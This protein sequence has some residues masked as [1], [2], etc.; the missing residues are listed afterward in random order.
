MSDVD[1]TRSAGPSALWAGPRDAPAVFVLDPDG[2]GRHGD[3]PAAWRPLVEHLQVLWCRLPAADG[4]WREVS[5][6]LAEFQGRDVPVHLLT[7]GPAAASALYLA[8]KYRGLVR[9]VLLVDPEEGPDRTTGQEADIRVI[10][11][12]AVPLGHPDVV[13]AVVK[14]LLELDA[15]DDP[16]PVEPSPPSLLGDAAAALRESITSV[17]DRVRKA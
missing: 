1:E 13:V 10:V 16:A 7:G 15:E 11:R 8:D 2:G 9:S 14:A 5:D 6:L 4:P 3:L 17:L 12:D